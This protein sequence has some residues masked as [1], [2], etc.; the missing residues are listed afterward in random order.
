MVFSFV[1]R[2]FRDFLYRADRF[3]IPF[4]LKSLGIN[5]STLIHF[6]ENLLASLFGSSQIR[7]SA[8]SQFSGHSF[9]TTLSVNFLPTSNNFHFW[10]NDFNCGTDANLE[11]TP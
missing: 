4:W 9:R 5:L 8:R 11:Q 6:T 7:I 2:V 10:G 3:L 1:N